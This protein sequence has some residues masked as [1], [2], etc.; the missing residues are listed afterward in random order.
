MGGLKK[1]LVP[2]DGSDMAERAVGWAADIAKLYEAEL[3]L[4]YVSLLPEDTD[5]KRSAASSW[6]PAI[7]TVSVKK[8]SHGI[9]EKMTAQLDKNMQVTKIV[10]T[11]K[12]EE[13]IVE[14]ARTEQVDLVAIGGR[15]L[16]LVEGFL[17]G[18]VSQTVLE[19][20]PCPVMIVK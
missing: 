18:S 14:F 6:L 5:D 10:R 1:I 9:M 20:A 16:G 3:V 12:P 15:G 11:G 7:A 19:K 2:V 4:L 8:V 13:A 17:L